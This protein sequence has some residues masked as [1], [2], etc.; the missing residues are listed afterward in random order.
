MTQFVE[1]KI[2]ALH[3]FTGCGE[4]F[5]LLYSGIEANWICPDLPGHGRFAQAKRPDFYLD[6]WI[7]HL[8]PSLPDKDLVG[9]GYSMGGRLLLHLATAHPHKFRCLILVGPNPG[10]EKRD[11]REKR[12][13]DDKQLAKRIAA[14]GMRDFLDYWSKTSL[15]RTQAK[16][17]PESHY[18]MMQQWRTRQNPHGLALSLL[19]HG[20]GRLPSLWAQ[21]AKLKMPVYL[22]VGEEDTKFQNIAHQMLSLLREGNVFV[23]PNA[24]HAAHLE[25]ADAF[26]KIMREIL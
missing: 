17:I 2:L 22:M 26:T 7:R 4:D 3:G 8:M 6:N 10:L 14:D 19:C 15:I 23:L 1:D 25:N 13:R 24:G 5:R 9:L 12:R 16:R 11:D 20:T 18:S 21:L